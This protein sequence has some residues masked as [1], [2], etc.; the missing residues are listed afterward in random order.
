MCPVVTF[1]Q[2][3]P[4]CKRI[5]IFHASGHEKGHIYI[6]TELNKREL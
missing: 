6:D 3:N 5:L 2:K 1:V 4:L